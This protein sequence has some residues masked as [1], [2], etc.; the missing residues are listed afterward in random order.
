MPRALWSGLITFG[1]VSIPVKLFS[2]VE[3]KSISFHQIHAACG[4]RI[5][6]V[7]FCPQ[8]DREVEWSELAKGYEY[9]KGE[10]VIVTPEDLETL[11]LSSKD[12]LEIGSFVQLNEVDPIYFEKSYFL[13]ADKSAEKPFALFLRTLHDQKMVAIAKITLRNKERLCCLRSVGSTLLLETLYFVDE[14]RVDLQAPAAKANLS[15][16]ELEMAAHLVK[17]MSQK[18]EPDKY[19]DGY[20]QALSE[21]IDAKLQGKRIT[22]KKASKGEVIDLVEALKASVS[23]VSKQSSANI[24]Q[25]RAAAKKKVSAKRKGSAVKG[26]KVKRRKTA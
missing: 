23:R 12:V 11:P 18:F 25:E 17:L 3:N 20:R 26:T 5:R 16:S 2:A 1:L 8:C 19:Q 14:I 24:V 22:K 4:T 21:I 7:R 10:Y 9:A 13:E 6:E 15:K